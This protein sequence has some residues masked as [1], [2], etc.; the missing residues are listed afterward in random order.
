MLLAGLGACA[1]APLPAKV[2]PPPAPD[3]ARLSKQFEASAAALSLP[4]DLVLAGRWKN[5]GSLLGQLEAW[6]GGRLGVSSWIRAHLGDPSRPVD[7]AAPIEVIVVLD[8]EHDPP[9]LAW[10]LSVGLGELAVPSKNGSAE[11]QDVESPAGL[12]CAE[13]KALGAAPARLVCAPDDDQLARLL[14]HATRA[15]PLA[16]VGD[17]ELSFSVRGAPLAGLESSRLRALAASLLTGF[18]GEIRI[19]ARFG[20]QW[21]QVVD[22]VARELAFLAQDLDGASLQVSLGADERAL[23]VSMLAPAAAGRS[24]LAQLAVGLGASGLAP[25]AFWQTHQASDEAWFSWAFQAAPLAR[26]RE[27]LATLLGT[28]LDYRGVPNRLEQQARELVAYLPMPRG[29]VIHASGRLPPARSVREQRAPW[30]EALGWQL[31]DVRGNFAEY[32]YYA[33]A[34]AKSFNDEILGP[35]FGRLIKSAFGPRWVP[36]RLTQR[37]PIG[38]L[39]RG[40]FVLDVSFAAPPAEPQSAGPMVEGAAAPTAAAP[41]WYAVFVPDEDGVRMA[42]GA[43][44][45]FL[46]SLLGQPTRAHASATL[47]GRAGLGSLNEHRVL[48]GG[49]FSLAAIEAARRG[50]LALGSGLG[51]AGQPA[52]TPS[53]ILAAP[54]RGLTPI[55]YALSQPSEA[56][57]HLTARFGRET[58]EDLSFLLGGAATAP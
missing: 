53:P 6:S 37:P 10:A 11:P 9:A 51:G 8:R 54:H 39:P 1:E 12:V 35:Q 18:F 2:A 55:V 21:A 20:E 38:A 29:P 50:S 26:L 22:G 16:R 46:I 27:P 28:V 34:L 5:P 49:F 57:L 41:E 4:D 30:L 45:R 44:E 32:Q 23:E 58:L 36:V 42:W 7:L 48:G 15:L 3:A 19:N 13:R 43:D 25:T 17:A 24:T 40:S 14:P 31:F 33:G 56:W 47:A 52:A